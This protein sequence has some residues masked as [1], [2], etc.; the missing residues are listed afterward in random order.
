LNNPPVNNNIFN[1]TAIGYICIPTDQEIL[2]QARE[3][4]EQ[5]TNSEHFI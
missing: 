4:L 5:E 3:L 1:T 2:D